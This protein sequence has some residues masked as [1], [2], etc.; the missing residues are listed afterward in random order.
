MAAI[1]YQWNPFQ[2]RIDNRVSNEVIKTA[3]QN[4]RVEFIPRAAPFFSR[5]F[6]L[7]VRGSAT[8]LKL[9]VDYVF[10]HTFDRFIFKYSRN[11]F[12]SVILLKPFTNTVLEASYDNIG[13][14]FILDEIAFAETVANIV[15]MPRQALWE[16]VVDVP[17]EFPSDP[18]E[19]PASQ[20]YDYIEM[21][22]ALRSLILAML[23][24]KDEV[25]VK[26]LLEEHVNKPLI[27]AHQADKTDFGLDDV[28]N[29][30]S[31]TVE[32]LKGNSD[33]KNVTVNVLKEALR[34]LTA[35]TL[36]LN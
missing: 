16:D 15:N 18:H 10:G 13:G 14:P 36:P 34:Q 23:E 11:A 20:T 32:D 4:N 22:T 30:A 6:V 27:Q 21:F 31:A 3:A 26:D 9:G 1:V 29:N 25:S 8:P 2:E 19:H 5:N 28:V 12:G 33:S 24:T 17:L 7:K 35:G